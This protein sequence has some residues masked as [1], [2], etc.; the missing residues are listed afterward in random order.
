[1]MLSELYVVVT[2]SVSSLRSLNLFCTRPIAVSELLVWHLCLMVTKVEREMVTSIQY[3]QPWKLKI[4]TWMT[5]RE[6]FRS[7]L[8]HNH[9]AQQSVKS[10]SVAITP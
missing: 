10:H 4:H 7:A 2:C 1:M 5:Q 8:G 6:R 9:C 3:K